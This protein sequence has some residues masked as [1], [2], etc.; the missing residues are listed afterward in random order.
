MSN[1][2]ENLQ[3]L[4]YP[5][6][7]P[8][9][10]DIIPYSPRKQFRFMDSNDLSNGK[11]IRLESMQ[12]MSIDQII[13]LYKDGFRIEGASPKSQV[14]TVASDVTVSSDAILLIGIGI[15]AYMMLKR[16]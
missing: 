12:N 5:K 13:G 10:N 9:E 4:S 3:Q 6:L 16:K 11:T 14:M 1:E 8:N 15:F 2:Y 7:Y